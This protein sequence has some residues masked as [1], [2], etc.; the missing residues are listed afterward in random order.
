MPTNAG[1]VGVDYSFGYFDANLNALIDLGSVQDVKISAQ[2][3]DLKNEPYNGPPSFDYAPDGYKLTFRLV[4]TKAG[5]EDLMIQR[6]ANF[7]A[8]GINKSGYL[9]E[10]INN[11]DGTVSRYQYTGFVFFM[12]E[13][14]DISRDKLVM[15]SCEGM[16]SS[17]KPI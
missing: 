11:A 2:K 17:K 3:K 6:E 4:R 9:N 5:L 7:N 16:A 13:R 12:G 14:G 8:G 10:T 15:Q 1:S